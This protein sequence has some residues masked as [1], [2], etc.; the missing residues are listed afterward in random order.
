LAADAFWFWVKFQLMPSDVAGLYAPVVPLIHSL[1]MAVLLV[2]SV[3]RASVALM[4]ICEWPP[5]HQA[6][7]VGMPPL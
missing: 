1:K 5:S 4:P 3:T 2:P 7:P 6:G